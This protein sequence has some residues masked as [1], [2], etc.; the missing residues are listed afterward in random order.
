MSQIPVLDPDAYFSRIGYAGSRAPTLETLRALHK[1]HA[2][3]I[4]FENLNPL[5]GWP[6]WLDAAS[7]EKKLVHGGRGGYCFEQ[8]LLFS[9]VL[10]T[11]GFGVIDL[12]ARVLW[13]S[14]SDDDVRPRTHMLLL[15]DVQGE[16]HIADVGFGGQSLTGPLRFVT[17][18][19]Q[20]TPHEPFRLLRIDGAEPAEYK[21]Q[22][23]VGK[24]WKTLY[25]FDLQPQ[26]EGDYELPNHYLCTSDQSHFRTTLAAARALPDRRYGLANNFLS[27]HHLHGPSERRALKSGAEV[28]QVL[29]EIFGIRLPDDARSREQLDAAIARVTELPR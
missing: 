25:R 2:A 27:T 21:L 1:L 28:R 24:V 11:L 23:L 8:N 5:A 20:P 22:A 17:D 19:E 26:L 16:K 6:V 7:I 12:A 15:V 10:K 14:R 9:R 13:R 4:P 3:A 29:T 18:I